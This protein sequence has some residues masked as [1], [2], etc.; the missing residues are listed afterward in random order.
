[1]KTGFQALHH[2]S[3]SPVIDGCHPHYIQTLFPQHL[4]I[5][6]VACDSKSRAVAIA[7]R[8][9]IVGYGH[10]LS[11]TIVSHSFLNEALHMWV[12]QSCY[13]QSDTHVSSS[14]SFARGVR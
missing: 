12:P 1:M 4:L 2:Y 8:G 5:V 11:R 10:E 3:A 13:P 7:R 14:A 9:V 6:R